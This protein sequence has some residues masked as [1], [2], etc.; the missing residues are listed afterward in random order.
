MHTKPVIAGSR[1][2]NN[3][4]HQAILPELKHYL[5]LN[6]T[7]LYSRQIMTYHLFRVGLTG[8][9][10]L[11]PSYDALSPLPRDPNV[12]EEQRR[13]DEREERERRWRKRDGN[14]HQSP[15]R[16]KPRGRHRSAQ[17]SMRNGQV[18]HRQVGQRDR[19]SQ[20]SCQDGGHGGD[21]GVPRQDHRVRLVDVFFFNQGPPRHT[22]RKHAS[23]TT[24]QR[25]NPGNPR[26]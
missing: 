19:Q 12:G 14:L 25:N 23:P 3:A 6:P 18:L 16:W 22:S 10:P 4:H 5:T 17:L 11:P 7:R 8:R 26:R 24:S 9:H 2:S 1:S 20:G 21:P 13:P 15:R